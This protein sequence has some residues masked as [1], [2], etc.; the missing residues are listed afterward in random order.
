MRIFLAL[1][2]FLVGCELSTPIAYPDITCGVSDAWLSIGSVLQPQDCS[3]SLIW[4]TNTNPCFSG[5]RNDFV[6]G[7][8]NMDFPCSSPG[9]LIAVT[10]T[11]VTELWT[12]IG[13]CH[14]VTLDNSC[15]TI[16]EKSAIFE[17]D[18]TRF[19]AGMNCR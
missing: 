9:A 6:F 8:Y 19:N 18:K 17:I 16:N 12:D 11:D 2:S 4:A 10:K 3:K 1:L 7:P 5:K 13:G 14:C 15:A